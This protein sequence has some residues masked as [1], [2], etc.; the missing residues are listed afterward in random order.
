MINSFAYECVF[1]IRTRTL[2]QNNQI[3]EIEIDYPD[4]YAGACYNACGDGKI[5]IYLTDDQ[6]EN[7]TSF[8]IVMRL[9]FTK[10]ILHWMN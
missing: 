7:Y 10:L 2:N 1:E 8:L 5:D 9:I 6:K 3:A 4:N